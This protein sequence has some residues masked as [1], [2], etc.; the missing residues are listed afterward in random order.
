M[1]AGNFQAEPSAMFSTIMSIWGE[2]EERCQ[3]SHGSSERVD[4][5]WPLF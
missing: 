4:W 2:P 3:F 5:G 1:L